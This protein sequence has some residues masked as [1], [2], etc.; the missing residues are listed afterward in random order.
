VIATQ[1]VRRLAHRPAHR[2][3]PARRRDP[4]TPRRDPDTPRRAL[5]HFALAGVVMVVLIAIGGGLVSRAVA[6]DQALDGAQRI[7]SVVAHTVLEPHL[8]D[9]LLTGDPAAMA[10]MREALLTSGPVARVKLWTADG[11]I[12]FSD[13][14]RLIGQQYPLG[15]EETETLVTGRPAA[16]ISDLSRSEN[17]FE[18]DMGTMLE[19][20]RPVHT[21][22]GQVLLF[23]TYMP[24][25]SV[26]DRTT[27]IWLEF[28]PITVGALVLLQLVQ[29]PLAAR[30]ARQ[31]GNARR[32]RELMLHR[33]LAASDAERRRIAADLHDG[34]VQDLAATSI[35][36]AGAA[37]TAQRSGHGD[38]SDRLHL[39]ADAVR[40]GIRS[41]RSLVVD[42]HPPNLRRT[43]LAAAL[44]DLAAA[45]TARGVDATLVV[46]E[47]AVRGLGG[48]AEQFA[49]RVAQEA[50]RNAIT[51]GG[52]SAVEMRLA[53]RRG[54]QGADLLSLSVADDGVGF[55][56]DA[57][58][59]DDRP[60]MGL[61]LLDD[62]AGDIGGRIDVTS[63]PGAGTTVKVEVP[64][65]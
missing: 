21:P 38:E 58:A 51:H 52:A 12:V 53:R 22:G 1:S 54:E 16:E 40:A 62:L 24:M 2:A 42:I 55:D 13:D 25:S 17:A 29:F 20:Y 9:G 34:V 10:T 44:G 14:P 63:A 45:T 6:E 28:L 60:R 49:F 46:D 32:D 3:A 41:L 48:P 18:R 47:D 19:V 30:L 35:A 64:V 8:R 4:D 33:S 5:V 11:R 15:I 37:V 23:E 56:P 57:G 43:G 36:L 31:T 65:G 50:L 27:A 61:R 7:N 26:A 59:P 39:A